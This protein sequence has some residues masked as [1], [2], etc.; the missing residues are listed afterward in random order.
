MDCRL[1]HDACFLASLAGVNAR[2]AGNSATAAPLPQPVL[3]AD[4]TAA[5]A[6]QGQLCAHRVHLQDHSPE[7]TE[8]GTLPS[9]Q[10]GLQEPAGWQHGCVHT[11]M[12]PNWGGLSLASHPVS[13]A[14]QQGEGR[15]A[16]DQEQL[17]DEAS[18]SP[19]H[20]DAPLLTS[21]PTSAG[22]GRQQVGS[23]QREQ[24]EQQRQGLVECLEQ[25]RDEAAP[26][27]EHSDAPLLVSLETGAGWLQQQ[28]GGQQQELQGQQEQ[29]RQREQQKQQQALVECLEQLDI[30]AVASNSGQMAQVAHGLTERC[31]ALQPQQEPFEWQPTSTH[32]LP[33][34]G[35]RPKGPVSA[36]ID[37]EAALLAEEVNEAA[38]QQLHE[39]SPTGS[40]PVGQSRPREQHRWGV[41]LAEQ[42]QATSAQTQGSPQPPCGQHRRLPLLLQQQRASAQQQKQQ[43]QRQ[44]V[45]AGLLDRSL[46]SEGSFSHWQDPWLTSAMTAH[47]VVGRVELQRTDADADPP[48]LKRTTGTTVSDSDPDGA[49]LG[50]EVMKQTQLTVLDVDL[51]KQPRR[52]DRCVLRV[53]AHLVTLPRLP[54][55]WCAS[56]GTDGCAQDVYGLTHS[57][58]GFFQCHN[59]K[60]PHC[61]WDGT[62]C[63]CNDCLSRRS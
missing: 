58:V 57:S 19:E 44:T 33:G 40:P 25:L 50:V 49:T 24:D 6:A 26:S 11:P 43:K 63:A 41:P 61:G 7:K 27:P 30:A 23:Q 51:V 47:L 39:A 28:V 34:Q 20:S 42:G 45:P 18:P 37:G 2:L 17:R 15:V 14:A 3:A 53:D 21:S 59:H 38:M 46:A 62:A 16:T 55:C 9:G 13:W 52:T 10:G 36:R 48:V 54:V 35:A 5:S 29:Q 1:G 60:H 22:W 12:R 31:P 32:C 4:F 56:L 8:T